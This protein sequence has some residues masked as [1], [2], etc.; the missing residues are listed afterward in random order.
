M[1][2]HV[3]LLNRKGFPIKVAIIGHSHLRQFC[4]HFPWD[5]GEYKL[6]DKIPSK[7]C[8]IIPQYTSTHVVGF[9]SLPSM[10]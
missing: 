9:L 2:Y 3:I 7:E 4:I 6:C 1:G 8:Y 5:L 10:T